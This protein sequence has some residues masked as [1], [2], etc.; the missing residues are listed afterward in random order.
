[1]DPPSDVDAA[2]QPLPARVRR[3]R[4][5]RVI[6][7][8]EF[9]R[10]SELSDEF[11]IS[12]VTVRSDLDAL[13][14]RHQVRRVRGGALART[15][16][17]RERPF[18]ETAVTQADQKAR[19]GAAAAAMVTDGE[20]VILDVGTTTTAIAR[21]LAARQDLRD[22]VVFTNG[23]TIAME[24]EQAIPPLTVVVTGGTLRP[25]QHSLVDPMGG[26]LLDAVQVDTVFLGCNGVDP[27]GG[28][29]NVN[30]PEAQVKQRML[31]RAGRRI[32]VADGSKIG[33]V[34]LTRLC[35]IAEVDLLLTDATADPDVVAE[36]TSRGLDVQITD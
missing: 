23:L 28:V 9:V 34:A 35:D 12:E 7:D 26:F 8:R 19:I 11:S 4:M 17:P 20:T 31:R 16:S 14:E 24:L 15:P 21:E 27:V 13:A 36:L 2:R 18:E 5:L 1:M 3:E 22:V 6:R 33:V 10:V 30:L 32:V 25:L 29:T